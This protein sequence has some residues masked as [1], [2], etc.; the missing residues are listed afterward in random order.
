MPHP[1]TVSDQQMEPMSSFVA[2]TEAMPPTLDMT[3]AED[4]PT[5]FLSNTALVINKRKACGIGFS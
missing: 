4:T 3:G 1:F 5:T 2:G